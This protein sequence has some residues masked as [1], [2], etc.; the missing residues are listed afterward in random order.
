M[1]YHVLSRGKTNAPWS[2][3]AFDASAAF[4]RAGDAVEYAAKMAADDCDVYI[5]CS[6]T[7]KVYAEF[8]FPVLAK[9]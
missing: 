8:E 7:D 4:D 2:A 1:T 6:E 5:D 3:R 9:L